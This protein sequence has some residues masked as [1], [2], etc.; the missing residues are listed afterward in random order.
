LETETRN[1]SVSIPGDEL[2]TSAMI[3]EEKNL[4]K[5][6]KKEEKQLKEQAKKVLNASE[7]LEHLTRLLNKS[8]FYTDFMV[9]QIKEQQEL[10]KQ[11]Q[12]EARVKLEALTRKEAKKQTVACNR[13]RTDD[14][15]VSK[16]ASPQGGS[17]K[18]KREGNDSP[19]TKKFKQEKP[20]SSDDEQDVPTP[21]DRAP[22]SGYRMC[23]GER[24]SDRQ[25]LYLT[26]GAMRTYQLDGFE[27]LK[28][29]YENG[30]NCIL[31]DEMGLG[32]TIQCIA[33]LAHLIGMGVPGPYLICAPL[34]TLPNWIAEFKRFT[35]KIPVLLYHGTIDER[36]LLRKKIRK[37]VAVYSQKVWP[38][39]VTSYEILI[40]DRRHFNDVKWRYLIIDEG[41]RIKNVQ[42]RLIQELKQCDSTNRLLLTGTP[43]QNNLSELWSLLNFL[44]PE[45]F[46][47][48]AVFESWFDVSALNDEGM[49]EQIVAQ[50]EEQQLLAKLHKILSP[51]M[52]RRVKSDVEILLPPKR[53]LLVYAPFTEQQQKYYKATMERAQWM[54]NG[55]ED[56]SLSTASGVLLARKSS[57][58]ARKRI[59]LLQAALYTSNEDT[60]VQWA[61][62]WD[63]EDKKPAMKTSQTHIRLQNMMMQ[64]RRCCNH[65]YLIDYPLD[66]VTGDFKVDE[67]LVTSCG[68][69]M[70]LD[71]MLKRLKKDGHKVLLFSQMTK[72]LDVLEDYCELRH[73]QYCRLDGT[74]KVEDRQIQMERFASDSEVLIFLLSTRAGG[75][76]INLTAADTVIIYD[77][78]WNPQCDL[79]AMDRCHRIGQT[80]PVMVYRLVTANTIDQRI[81]ER[82][83]SKRKLERLVIQPGKFTKGITLDKES[84]PANLSKEVLLELLQAKDYEE[85]YKA[86]SSEV[87][88][89]E[90]LD[91]LMDRTGLVAN[92]RAKVQL[93][94]SGQQGMDSV[95]GVFQVIETKTSETEA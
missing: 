67:G 14:Q 1:M 34:S 49:D 13:T 47:D 66:P 61:E 3:E 72:V 91:L 79:Q 12:K 86:G 43:L 77:S 56:D 93:Q 19:E 8:E 28:V 27:W 50:E 70:V 54:V 52:L 69:V 83:A 51:F 48:L 5:E 10:E 31:A 16:I 75:Q 85:A 41:H 84:A 39:T 15:T 21:D 30:I 63:Q 24:I 55:K 29:M 64:L 59:S 95:Q 62:D 53:E 7:R 78:D 17:Q 76:G 81:I 23:N 2:V 18:R 68:K 11:R 92:N 46:D 71:A 33:M 9:K 94:Q 20:S 74:M 25:P 87:F 36:A 45:I 60:L 80:R 42:C 37:P 40:R 44:I 38:V 58:K 88:T 26:G 90:Q 65:P 4:E 82:A 57:L 22:L 6:T 32:K 73:Y 35:P 89:S